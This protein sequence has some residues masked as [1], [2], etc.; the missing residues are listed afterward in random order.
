MTKACT[1]CSSPNR[2]AIDSGLS[3]RR[4]KRSRAC[5]TLRPWPRRRPPAPGSQAICQS[6]ARLRSGQL[7]RR[8][9]REVTI[10]SP[11]RA[12]FAIT[13]RG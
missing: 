9:R 10:C 8:V 6:P 4:S 1:V 3:A 2:P 5:S 13:P 12:R 7:G 11:R